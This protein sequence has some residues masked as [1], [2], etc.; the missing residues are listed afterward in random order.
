MH[1]FVPGKVIEKDETKLSDGNLCII[2]NFTIKNYENSEKFR[3]VNHDKQ[4]I[5]TTYTHIEKVEED[6]GFIQKNMFDFYDLGQLDDIA[7]KNIFLT[8]YNH[9]SKLILL[10][11]LNLLNLENNSNYILHY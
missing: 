3:V 11:L 9:Q 2:S 8:G 10:N 5:L 6:D 4:I 7:D 1:A